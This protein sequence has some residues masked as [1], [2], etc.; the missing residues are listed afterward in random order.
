MIAKKYFDLERRVEFW[1]AWE[2]QG[3]DIS[4]WEVREIKD[5]PNMHPLILNDKINQK[6]WLDENTIRVIEKED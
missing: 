5:Q 3:S 6:K 1:S 2:V 4:C